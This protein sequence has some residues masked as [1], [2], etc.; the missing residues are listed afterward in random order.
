MILQKIAERTIQRVADE[1]ETVPLSEMKKRAE[2]LDSNTGFPFAKALGGSDISF[3]C[4]VKRASP[5]K[6][7]IAEDFP[8]LDIARDYEGGD[9]MPYG[10]VLVQGQRRVPAR[11]LTCG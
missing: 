7:L 3:I 1:K 8:Y 6:G 9:I 11:D 10:A 4:E 5:S 2:A